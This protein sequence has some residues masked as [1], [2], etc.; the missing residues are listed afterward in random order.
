MCAS[1]FPVVDASIAWPPVLRPCCVP[2][3][4]VDV[5]GAECRFPHGVVDDIDGLAALTSSV[6]VGLHVDN[7]LGGFLLSHLAAIGEFTRGFDF[8]VSLFA[9]MWRR[10]G[11]FCQTRSRLSA[12]VYLS[13]PSLICVP[14]ATLHCL[15]CCDR[16]P[17]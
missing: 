2:T 10:V 15:G 6:G 4:D 9:S 8:L 7:C 1:C 14:G 3:V 5:A 17:V 12:V 16:F 11:S 13:A